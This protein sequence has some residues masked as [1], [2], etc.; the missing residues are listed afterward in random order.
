MEIKNEW[1]PITDED[2]WM[3]VRKEHKRKDH[4]S[5]HKIKANIKQIEE[6]RRDAAMEYKS[7]WVLEP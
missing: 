1:K 5:S 7:R 6:N 2:E 3:I 4:D